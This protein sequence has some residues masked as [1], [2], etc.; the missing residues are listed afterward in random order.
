MMVPHLA[1]PPCPP[2]RCT[3][4]AASRG[5]A[6][7]RPGRPCTGASASAAAPR[8]LGH[9]FGGVGCVDLRILSRCR[10]GMPAGA[11]VAAGTCDGTPPCTA[12]R[13]SCTAPAPHTHRTRAAHAHEPTHART[14]APAY[15]HAH[16]R[17]RL[18]ARTRTHARMRVR[19]AMMRRDATYNPPARTRALMRPR[20]HGNTRARTTR[21]AQTHTPTR[22]V[23]HEC[24]YP[25]VHA[26]DAHY[27]RVPRH[28]TRMPKGTPLPPSLPLS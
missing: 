20:Q 26:C 18:P 8:A 1:L 22:T 27:A 5:G 11:C 12:L 15:P 10:R 14:H 17:T 2:S 3:C 9:A 28:T 13:R 4:A 19:N 21:T 23:N 6:H 24:T 7:H 16:A 25:H